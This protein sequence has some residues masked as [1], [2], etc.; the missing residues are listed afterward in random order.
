MAVSA[1]E[2][3]HH[4]AVECVECSEEINRPVSLDSHER[5]AGAPGQRGETAW[6]LSSACISVFSST[7]ITTALSGGFIYRV[8][9]YRPTPSVTLSL[10]SRSLHSLKERSR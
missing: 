10:H 9:V 4:G 2:L 8:F 1:V 3:R 6:F 7:Q 5:D